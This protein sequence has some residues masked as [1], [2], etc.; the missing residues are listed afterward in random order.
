MNTRARLLPELELEVMKVLWRL[1]AATV[2][3]TDRLPAF[4]F[5]AEEQAEHL[6]GDHSIHQCVECVK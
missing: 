1:D 6:R 2:A 4:A 3:D 5:I